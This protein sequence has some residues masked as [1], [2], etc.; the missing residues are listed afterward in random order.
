ML[1]LRN[2]G[3]NN[4]VRLFC[5]QLVMYFEPSLPE[6]SRRGPRRKQQGKLNRHEYLIERLLLRPENSL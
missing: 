6:D 4:K 3:V 1:S 5:S 2:N